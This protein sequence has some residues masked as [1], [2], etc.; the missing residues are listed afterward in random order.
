MT[1]LDP[2]DKR[3]A[4]RKPAP[5]PPLPQSVPRPRPSPAPRPPAMDPAAQAPLLSVPSPLANVRTSPRALYPSH[6]VW[7]YLALLAAAVALAPAYALFLVPLAALHLLLA[8]AFLSLRADAPPA[9]AKLRRRLLTVFCFGPAIQGLALSVLYAAVFLAAVLPA[10]KGA[11]LSRGGPAAEESVQE[12]AEDLRKRLED[13]FEGDHSPLLR[14]ALLVFFSLSIALVNAL[15]VW[16]LAMGHLAMQTSITPEGIV[17]TRPRVLDVLAFCLV[18]ALAFQ[19]GSSAL[20]LLS[21]LFFTLAV[22][23]PLPA[24]PH[25]LAPLVRALGSLAAMLSEQAYIALAVAERDVLGMGRGVFRAFL[26]VWGVDSLLSACTTVTSA[27]KLPRLITLLGA[28][29]LYVGV[30]AVFLA[31]C[32]Q[33][34]RK[35]VSEEA[36]RDRLQEGGSSVGP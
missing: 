7:L 29:A 21:L 26:V 5:P 31:V 33:R 8:H 11:D 2:V 25:G 20:R 13:L 35:D 1:E 19:M 17:V 9:Q 34:Y 10:L 12:S 6:A 22:P 3:H 18:G 28:P 30:L 16:V 14:L 36:S 15:T 24:G 32:W 23:E 4:A 27:K